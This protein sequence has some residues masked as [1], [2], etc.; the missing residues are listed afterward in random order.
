MK[1][2]IGLLLVC[3]LILVGCGGS[4]DIGLGRAEYSI[5]VGD[6]EQILA[7]SDFA[8]FINGL[9]NDIFGED[10]RITDGRAVEIA[11]RVFLNGVEG[12]VV[13]QDY[14]D[15]LEGSVFY[16]Y[17]FENRGIYVVSRWSAEP[18]LGWVHSVIVCM[19]SGSASGI[20]LH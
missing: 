11:N 20:F 17:T 19:Y 2:I 7:R 6:F 13:R 5:V 9:T 16:V 15:W 14:L 4:G 3:F 10:D 12:A 8:E 1:R 18:E